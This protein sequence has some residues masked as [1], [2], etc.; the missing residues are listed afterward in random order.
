MPQPKINLNEFA[1]GAFAERVNIALNEVY[2]NIADKNTDPTKKRKVTITMSLSADE[3]RDLAL[4]D[5]G[6]KT[7]LTPARTIGSKIIIDVDSDGKA[8]GQEL[9]SGSPGQMMISDGGEIVNDV[10]MPIEEESAVPN[11][12]NV[13]DLRSNRS[14]KA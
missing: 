4:V 2:A 7:V 12:D 5:I 8:V 3:E 9:K 11:E 13:I 10:G 14:A 6:V 1:N